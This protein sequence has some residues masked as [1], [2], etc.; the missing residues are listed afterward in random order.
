MSYKK[1]CVQ[2]PYQHFLSAMM[3]PNILLVTW[4]N[5]QGTVLTYTNML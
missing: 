2:F 4:S 3:A 1:S 5:E